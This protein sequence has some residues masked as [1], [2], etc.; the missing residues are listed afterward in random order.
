MGDAANK[1]LEQG[2]KSL[3]RRKHIKV[4]SRAAILE[5]RIGSPERARILF[6]GILRNYPKRTDLWSVYL[7]QEI[8]LGN[9]SV[10]RALFERVICLELPPRKMKV[11][12]QAPIIPGLFME[13]ICCIDNLVFS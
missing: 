9:E 13:Q 6:E 1:A 12:H 4:I 8:R 7:D 10:I 11:C 2:L 3:P 5:F